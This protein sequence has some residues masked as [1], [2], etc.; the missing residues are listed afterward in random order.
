MP[1]RAVMM[2]RPM[3]TTDPKAIS[4]MMMA[5]MIPM[6]S[7][8]PGWADTVDEI[9]SPPSATW[10]P[11]WAKLWATFDQVFGSV[12]IQIRGGLVELDHGE[13]DVPVG[14]HLLARA[15]C[16]RAAHSAHVR[17]R[18]EGGDQS[19]DRGRVGRVFDRTRGVNDDVGGVPGLGREPLRQQV[20]GP[21]RRRVARGEVVAEG[22]ADDVGQ[23]DHGHHD[24]DPADDDRPAVVVTPPGQAAES[25]D[26]RLLLPG[27]HA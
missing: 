21:L 25:A 12:V 24:D 1:N 5:A 26:V 27:V 19:S 3:A 20:L 8:E 13:G 23:A 2:G 18:T 6:P 15:R 17:E 4:M 10:Y 11:G 16:E 7:L 14:R 9:G 22:A